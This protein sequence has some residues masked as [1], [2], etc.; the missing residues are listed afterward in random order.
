MM[1]RIGFANFVRGE[2]S[3]ETGVHHLKMFVARVGHALP[4]APD[5]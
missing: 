2:K 5:P 1:T 4:K 3:P